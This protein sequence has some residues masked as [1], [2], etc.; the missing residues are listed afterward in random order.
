MTAVME[1]ASVSAAAA[2][3]IGRGYAVC[4]IAPGEK[5]PTYKG[6]NLASL[7]PED[8]PNGCNIGILGGPLS[9]NLVCI[10]LDSPE[11]IKLADEFLPWTGMVEGRPGKPCSHRWYRVTDIPPELISTAAG[12][13]GGPK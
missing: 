6:W 10:D 5:R 8:F 11:A 1:A 9:S 2:E 3:Y 12:G 4:K 13:I 7:S